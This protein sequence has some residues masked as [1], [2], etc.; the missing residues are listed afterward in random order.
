LRISPRR[1]YGPLEVKFSPG[2]PEEFCTGALGLSQF[3]SS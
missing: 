2:I 3:P 1:F